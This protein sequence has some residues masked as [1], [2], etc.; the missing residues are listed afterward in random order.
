MEKCPQSKALFG[1]PLESDPKSK[2]I[3]ESHRFQ[4]HSTFTI[5]MFDSVI[6]TLGP[7]MDVLEEVLPELLARST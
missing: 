4:I 7:E 5:Q 6:D 1:F 3:I 2:D